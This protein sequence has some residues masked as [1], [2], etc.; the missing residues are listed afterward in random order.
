MVLQGNN[1]RE[2]RD[3][4]KKLLEE[5]Q[6]SAVLGYEHGRRGSRPAF[7]TD[8]S[9]CERL[10]F[11]HQCVQNLAAYLSPRRPHLKALGRMAVVIKACDA[12]AVAGLIRESQ[13]KREDVVLIGVRCG[14]VV[15]D[16]N[17]TEPLSADT[18]APRCLDCKKREPSLVDYLVGEPQP[19]PPGSGSRDAILAEIEAM[20]PSERMAY[21]STILAR[22]TRCNACRQVCPMCFCERC[23][24]EKTQPTWI[25]TSAH[26][27][28]NL[29]W[30]L[31][32]ALHLAGRCVDCG[33]CE[34]ACPSQIPLGLLNRKLAR[35][36]ADRYGYSVTDDPSAAAPVGNY[37][38]DDSQEF[39]R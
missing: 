10:V 11:D 37:R 19:D 7:V 26:P 25:E 20:S 36:V 27:R 13:I 9:D 35:V 21:W 34:R 16:P 15:R 29:A 6:V 12:R 3:L 33:E 17:C 18:I 32:R 8:A 28:G 23:I 4:A 2:L 14:G 31:T 24:A 39:I 38:L 22:C 5:K 1:M 30:N